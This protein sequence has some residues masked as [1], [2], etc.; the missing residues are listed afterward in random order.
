MF[1]IQSLSIIVLTYPST[2]LVFAEADRFANDLHGD[3]TILMEKAQLRPGS[4]SLQKSC[5]F[6][7]FSKPQSFG[8]GLR[9]WNFV[10]V[11][12][13]LYIIYSIYNSN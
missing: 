11:R 8:G 9:V 12:Y 5:D 3:L 6:S 2:R 4:S 10:K 7:G 13:I 1:L